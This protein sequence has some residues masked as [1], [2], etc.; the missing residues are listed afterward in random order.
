MH[1]ISRRKFVAL[2]ATGVAAAPLAPITRSWARAFGGASSAQQLT[3]QEVIDRIK[4]S[5]GGDWSAETVDGFKAGDPATPVTGIVTTSL[6]SL[7]VLASAVKARANLVIT[8]EPTFYAKA[9]SPTPPVRRGF[10]PPGG[11]GSGSGSGAGAAPASGGPPNAL[12]AQ[13]AE[14]PAP[15][16]PD[17]VFTAKNDFLKKNNLVVWR[18]SDHWRLHTP[19]PYAQGLV[20][21]CGWQKFTAAGD[22]AHLAIPGSSLD[23]LVAHVKKSLNARG[24]IRVVGDPAMRVEKIAL[25]PGTTPIQS[26]IQTLPGVDAILAGEVREWE[27]VEYVRDVVA[28]GRNKA[29]I[30]VGRYVSEDPGMKLCAQWL[31]T[32]VPEVRSTWISAGDPYWRPTL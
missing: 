23:A 2:S 32:L 14:P 17:P 7:A 5:I 8:C 6:A 3:A 22:P 18:F 4:Q 31:K 20:D 19:D 9:D 13:P 11:A 24:G 27:S 28:L 12:P 29:L 16:P 15:P 25:L 1:R 21:A 26:S 10:A 30:L